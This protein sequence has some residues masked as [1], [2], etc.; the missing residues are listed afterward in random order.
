MS[1]NVQA[2]ALNA[3]H[4]GKMVSLEASDESAIVGRVTE[5][6]H[7]AVGD[8]AETSIRVQVLL[9]A[10]V[11]VSLSAGDPITFVDE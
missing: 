8:F 3:S 10:S 6:R 4:I 5:V 1:A 11:E 7:L 9:T 2:Y